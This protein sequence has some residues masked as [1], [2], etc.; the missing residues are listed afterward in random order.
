MHTVPRRPPFSLPH[1]PSS[2]SHLPNSGVLAVIQWQE[3]EKH[4]HGQKPCLQWRMKATLMTGYSPFPWIRPFHWQWPKNQEWTRRRPNLSSALLTDH[5]RGWRA[6]RWCAWYLAHTSSPHLTAHSN[7]S[8]SHQ[9]YGGDGS[10]R[11]SSPSQCRPPHI[12]EAIAVS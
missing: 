12:M 8:P 11:T 5:V 2:L 1:H 6:G 4:F 7:C 9:Q 10:W 3:R